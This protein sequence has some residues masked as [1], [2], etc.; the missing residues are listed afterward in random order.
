[1]IFGRSRFRELVSSQLDLF[2]QDN[3]DLFERI[4]ELLVIH[5]ATGRDEAEE[6]FGDYLDAYGAVAELLEDMRDRY[7]RT[8]D[9]ADEYI[10]VFNKAVRKRLPVIAHE[11]E[12]D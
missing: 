5:N 2:Q 8:L 12:D 4:D 9:D 10:G 1:V 3:R 11:F 7:S 6:T